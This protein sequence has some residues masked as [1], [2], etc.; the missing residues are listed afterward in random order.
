MVRSVDNP[1]IITEAK[2]SDG[3]VG[4]W[5]TNLE[6]GGVGSNCSSTHTSVLDDSVDFMLFCIAFPT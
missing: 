3:G 4:G 2:M 1:Y 5:V 6:F